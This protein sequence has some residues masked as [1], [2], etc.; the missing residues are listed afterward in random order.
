[1]SQFSKSDWNSKQSCLGAENRTCI[2]NNILSIKV[3]NKHKVISS[4]SPFVEDKAKR[5]ILY[6]KY[7]IEIFSMY[8]Q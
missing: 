5:K 8:G 6:L 3:I 4:L 2:L 1:M 7:H